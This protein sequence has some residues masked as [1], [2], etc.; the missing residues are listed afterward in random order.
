MASCG[1]K[2]PTNQKSSNDGI[3]TISCGPPR[4]SSRGQSNYHSRS[5]PSRHTISQHLP[6]A[7][8][9]NQDG[10]VPSGRPHQSRWNMTQSDGWSTVGNFKK[11]PS[12]AQAQ[13]IATSNRFDA[14]N[15]STQKASGIKA[16]PA[17]V[18]PQKPQGVWSQG[19]P[20]QIFTSEKKVTFAG[21]SENLM[22][23]PCQTKTFDPDSPISS[24][25]DDGAGVGFENLHRSS[26][27]WRPKRFHDNTPTAHELQVQFDAENAAGEINISQYDSDED[28]SGIDYHTPGT[29][30]ELPPLRDLPPRHQGSW[31]E[32]MD[33]EED[34]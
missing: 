18:V 16:G 20:K 23:P 31:V 13:S 17:P 15:Q 25:E 9:R 1:A 26:N 21:D 2:R 28:E 3:L 7:N 22:K 14:F 27:A 29:Y 34:W 10:R 30:A 11:Q 8:A 33:L 19:A 32:M 4:G 24:S 5:H 6:Q 12:K